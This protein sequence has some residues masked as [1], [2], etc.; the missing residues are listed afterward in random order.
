MGGYGTALVMAVAM[1]EP[2]Q[3]VVR[4]PPHAIVRVDLRRTHFGFDPQEI[5]DD[6]LVLTLPLSMTPRAEPGFWNNL[7]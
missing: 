2:L 5:V 4:R 7:N 1:L 3:S 6:N